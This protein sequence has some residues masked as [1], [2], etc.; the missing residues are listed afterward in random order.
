MS[1]QWVDALTNNNMSNQEE[2]SLGAIIFIAAKPIVKIYLIMFLGWLLVRHNILTMETSR[3]IS[4]MVVNALLPCL[5]FNKIVTNLSGGQI[6]EIGVSVLTAMLVFGTGGALAVL[7]RFI[8]PVPKKWVWGLIFGGIFANISDLPIAYTQSMGTGIVFDQKQADKGV[9]ISC[10]FLACQQFLMMNMGMFQVVGLDFRDVQ[11]SKG[12]KD[13]EKGD[14]GAEADK[15]SEFN[16]VPLVRD[17]DDEDA[18]SDAV[19]EDSYRSHATSSRRRRRSS[20]ISR[21]SFS[22]VLTGESGYSTRSKKSKVQN[23]QSL[24]EEYSEAD[25]I[26][27]RNMDL[28]RTVSKTQEIGLNL[29]SD[30]EEKPT[31]SKWNLLVKKYKLFWLDYLLINLMRPAS[32]VLL[33]SILVAMVPWLRALFVSNSIHI[34]SAPDKLPPLNFV[35]DFT[36]YVGNAAIPMGLLLLGGT[37]A[38][39]KINEIPKGFWKTSLFLTLC[40][41]VLMPIIGVLWTNRLYSNG[42]ITD[43]ISRFVLIISWA[44]PSATAQV[45]FTAFYTP[46]EGDHIQMD[47]LAIFLLMQYPILIITL[48]ITVS[49]VLKVNL[50][51]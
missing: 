50:G 41:L 20:A 14:V 5:S 12:F 49:Y 17:E 28:G 1:Q 3:G 13:E 32:I 21:A 24:I 29:D 22:R 31:Y 35:M 37:I 39:L 38:R 42:W 27:S 34:H 30:E 51:Y 40:R 19:S 15:N 43:D 7:T 11:E 47:C 18:A 36:I 2:I 44:V 16:V 9:A 25:R 46:L 8:T 48:A 33:I 4:N 10:I 45:Y 6:K 23:I 26:K